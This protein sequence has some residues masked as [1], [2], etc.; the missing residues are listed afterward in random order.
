MSATSAS[1]TAPAP[2]GR[3]STS[4][5]TEP[6]APAPRRPWSALSPSA[7]FPTA[8]ARKWPAELASSVRA[9]GTHLATGFLATPDLLAVL[10]DH[11]HGEL[12]YALLLQDTS[13]SWLAMLERGA[14]TMWEDWDGVDDAGRPKMSYNHY[15]KGAVVSFLHTRTAGIRLADGADPTAAA[16]RRFVI[17]PV[18]GGGLTSARA[19]HDCPYGR[20]RSAWRIEDG[21]FTLSAAIPP[22]TSAQIRMPDGA[23]VE[24]GPGSHVLS[25]PAD[26]GSSGAVSA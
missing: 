6:S 19:E 2:R 17:E 7:S 4:L 3:P 9:A 26:T 22:G 20:I 21:V 14:T 11:G 25:C 1:P 24:A 13:P 12:A 5:P 23:R 15:S 10:A 8:C 16:Y 18:P